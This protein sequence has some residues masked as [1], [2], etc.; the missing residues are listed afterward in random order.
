M[1]DLVKINVKSFDETNH[2]LVVR[3]SAQE[4]TGYYE[5]PDLAFQTYN[6][7]SPKLDDIIKEL[8]SLGK[9]YIEQ[10]KQKQIL[11]FLFCLFPYSFLELFNYMIAKPFQM[12]FYN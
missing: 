4:G 5:T 2:T 6:F 12:I 3:F 11:S 7:K 10:E 9:A 8:G 1:V